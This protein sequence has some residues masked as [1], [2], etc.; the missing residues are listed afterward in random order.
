MDVSDAQFVAW[1]AVCPARCASDKPMYPKLVPGTVIDIELT[2]TLL[3]GYV[4]L[5]K[6][7]SLENDP[8]TL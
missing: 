7:S 2:A 6:M 1:A 4:A 3:T 8:V 5:M